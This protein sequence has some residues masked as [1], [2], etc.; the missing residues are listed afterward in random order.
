MQAMEVP[1]AAFIVLYYFIDL[2]RG[3]SLSWILWTV[4]LINLSPKGTPYTNLLVSSFIMYPIVTNDLLYKKI[5]QGVYIVCYWGRTLLLNDYLSGH[6]SASFD[7][8]EK[9]HLVSNL[10]W[11]GRIKSNLKLKASSI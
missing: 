5:L 3:Q 8:S 4:T 6:L 9:N 10:S 11:F 7:S 2:T 1:R